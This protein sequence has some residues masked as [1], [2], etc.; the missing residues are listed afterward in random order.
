MPRM[1]QKTKTE[2][3]DTI[4]PKKCVGCFK[5]G[6]WLCADC[7]QK[8][9]KERPIIH[10]ID[11]IKVYACGLYKNKILQNIVNYI[12]YSGIT[13]LSD[14]ASQ[15]MASLASVYIFD[16][17]DVIT[18]IPLHP[19]K[20]AERTF[21]QAEI[22]AR[23]IAKLLDSDYQNL[24]LRSKFTASQT[25]LSD[26]DRKANINGIFKVDQNSKQKIVGRTIFL[27]D[28]VITSGAT[29]SEAAQVLKEYGAYK[30]IGLCLASR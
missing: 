13:D 6:Q 5:I 24:L 20:E 17:I 11:Q 10:Q 4:F 23:D 29:I 14:T 30:V 28:D 15:L 1:I 27:V 25:H 12:K 9:Q 8:I 16:S 18:A 2:V 7:F 3:L 19:K 22:I 26:E 21:N